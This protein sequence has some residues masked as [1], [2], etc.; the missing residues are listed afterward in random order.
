MEFLFPYKMTIWVIGSVGLLM[1]LQLIVLDIA[2]LSQKHIPGFTIETNH[3]HFLFRAN[4]ALANS[5][6][7]LGIFILFVLF[8]LFSQ[9]MPHWI[10]GFAAVY[11]FGRIGHMLC[12]YFNMKIL[13]SVFFVVSLLGLIGL[14]ATAVMAWL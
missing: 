7:S 13:R 14:F 5:N 12:Y 3:E 8:A 9:P 2:I 11:L 1:L 6:E 4:R 10:N